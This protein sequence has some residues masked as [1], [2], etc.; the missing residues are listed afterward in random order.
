MNLKIQ[1]IIYFLPV[2]LSLLLASCET[3]EEE[4]YPPKGSGSGTVTVPLYAQLDGYRIK[5]RGTLANEDI[6]NPGIYVM[7]F[8]S[9]GGKP[10]E[11]KQAESIG[12]NLYVKLGKQ[13]DPCT[14]F[15]LANIKEQKL[16]WGN[17]I[18]VIEGLIEERYGSVYK[19]QEFKNF[20]NMIRTAK[21]A[22]PNGRI[23]TIPY[24][25]SPIPMSAMYTAENGI[26][27]SLT[28]GTEEDRIKLKRI[29]GK[30][31]IANTSS[32]FVL[33]E[34]TI[35]NV[36]NRGHLYRDDN[37]WYNMDAN[38]KTISYI[39]APGSETHIAVAVP[40]SDVDGKGTS[41]QTT[42]DNPIYAH[43]TVVNDH[44]MNSYADNMAIIVKG[45]YSRNGQEQVYYYRLPFKD[46]DFNSLDLL[47]NHEYTMVISAVNMPGYNTFDEA[48]NASTFDNRI[49]ASISVTDNNSMDI[50]DNGKYYLGVTNSEY[51]IYKQSGTGVY[52]GSILAGIY[53]NAG[54][55]IEWSITTSDSS[56]IFKNTPQLISNQLVELE[57]KLDYNYAIS[58]AYVTIKVGNLEKVITIKIKENFNSGVNDY[59]DRN[60]T[61]LY[62]G[63]ETEGY[64]FSSAQY[65]SGNIHSTFSY[66]GITPV[67]ESIYTI[68]GSFYMHVP[69]T[70]VNG[71]ANRR[72][73]LSYVTC[74]DNSKGRI[75]I[76]VQ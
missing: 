28:I 29:V 65:A 39:G 11:L 61:V 26:N 34:A 13:K 76:Y 47:R 14:L 32:D 17:D 20:P 1:H 73:T 72:Q 23:S 57:L 15:I 52:Q 33:Q 31:V 68:D 49:E 67:G 54:S 40:K 24:A 37:V 30:I 35:L 4:L 63:P 43:E 36:A 3:G 50:V 22:D 6:I 2:L 75:K 19:D 64:P 10:I 70:E 8:K 69:Y 66:D 41:G 56:V 51:W 25:N 18:N 59:K 42:A 58:P 48:C 45:S 53:T 44:G 62:F 46:D 55:E 7:V 12:G 16:V 9:S 74:T 60:G 21:L 5:T 38:A 71:V 27:E